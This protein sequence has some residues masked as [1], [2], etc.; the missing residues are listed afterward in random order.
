MDQPNC[1][2]P[3]APR[4]HLE[5]AA[6]KDRTHVATDAD[7]RSANYFTDPIGILPL[8]MGVTVYHLEKL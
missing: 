5:S 4:R 3:K 1:S 2:G 6:G 7:R 8:H